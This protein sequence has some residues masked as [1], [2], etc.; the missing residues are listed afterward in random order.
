MV[1]NKT[2]VPP[3]LNR[4]SSTLSS[5]LRTGSPLPLPATYRLD[6]MSAAAKRYK[7]LRRLVKFQQMDFE[8]A[9]WQMIYL[10]IA[11]QTVYRNFHYRKQTKSQFARDDPAFLVLLTFWLCASSLGFALVLR[12]SIW[13]FIKFLLY[14]I[15]VDCIG[16]GLMI[17]TIIWFISNKYLLKPSCR[18]QD[19]EWGYAFDVHLNAFFPLLII[20]HV[21]QPLLFSVLIN[22]DW[23]LSRLFGN[24]LWFVAL[25]YYVYITFLGY[26]CLPILHRT[27][28]FLYPLT[29]LLFMYIITLTIGWNI[30]GS[31]MNFYRYRVL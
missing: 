19:V 23:F 30:S 31:F 12:L 6:C 13:G 4:S 14:V 1:N 20:L 17:A 7:Y 25:G 29:A 5:T 15:F 16:V 28:I 24:T 8:F 3:P 27:N 9:M 11:P 22:H 2:F 26:S 10:F 21:F 18:D